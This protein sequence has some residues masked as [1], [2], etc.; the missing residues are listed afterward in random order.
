MTFVSGYVCP[1]LPWSAF[2]NKLFWNERFLLYFASGKSQFADGKMQNL[3][4][5]AYDKDYFPEMNSDDPLSKL[6]N[7]FYITTD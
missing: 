4:F 1:A 7:T 5:D 6:Q 3:Y 2:N